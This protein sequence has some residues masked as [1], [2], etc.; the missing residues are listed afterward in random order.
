MFPN[1]QIVT[2]LSFYPFILDINAVQKFEYFYQGR[3]TF[4]DYYCLV[5]LNVGFNVSFFIL[6]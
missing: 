1:C 5:G 3:D 4:N 6:F 2:I